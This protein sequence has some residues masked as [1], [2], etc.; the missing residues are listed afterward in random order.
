MADSPVNLLGLP[1]QGHTTQLGAKSPLLLRK[2][3]SESKPSMAQTFPLAGGP[4]PVSRQGLAHWRSQQGKGGS[5]LVAISAGDTTV[6]A[7]RNVLMAWCVGS[8]CHCAFEAGYNDG[9]ASG[10]TA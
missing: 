2:T 6:H 1:A 10:G 3:S 9:T 7:D 4:T 5:L 8:I